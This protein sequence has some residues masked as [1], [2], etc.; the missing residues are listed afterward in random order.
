M[1]A[2]GTVYTVG[3]SG[4]ALPDF[5]AELRNRG[6]TALIDVRSS[7]YSGYRQEYNRE[8]L[9]AALKR[10]GV[11]YRSYA[12]EF[13]ARQE[14]RSYY[15]REGYLDFARFSASP[16]FGEGAEKLAAGM[17]RG[18]VFVLMCAEKDP[19][20]CHRAVMVARAL[21]LRGFSVAHILPG[22]VTQTQEELDGRLLEK[23]F[24]DR[25]QMS[26]F[27]GGKSQEELVARA[28]ARQNAAIGYRIEEE[29]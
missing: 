28:Y 18:F 26:L 24:P 10:A 5:L 3:Y 7:P 29:N 8:P 2:E 20:A 4:F 13:G 14:D 11:V 15:T 23:Y 12:R 16:R 17:E 21:D 6:I 1:S 19:I 27:G 22:G 25:E 9:A